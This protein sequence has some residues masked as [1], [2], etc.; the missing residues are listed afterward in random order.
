MTD[1]D[2]RP[3]ATPRPELTPEQSRVFL[4]FCLQSLL[5]VPV[6]V[7]YTFWRQVP[8]LTWRDAAVLL[9]VLGLLW[10]ILAR[11]TWRIARLPRPVSRGGYVAMGSLL[12]LYASG[13]LLWSTNPDQNLRG[14]VTLALGLLLWALV[15]RDLLTHRR[16]RTAT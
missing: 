4:W 6:V 15:A 11:T 2:D 9:P 5:L 14:V 16:A 13:P 8:R 12:G 3:T 7:D 10:F 1:L